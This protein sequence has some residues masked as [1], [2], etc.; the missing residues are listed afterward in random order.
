MVDASCHFL[1]DIPTYWFY[2]SVDIFILFHLVVTTYIR[3]ESMFATTSLATFHLCKLFVC[4]TVSTT[5]E[6]FAFIFQMPS[7]SEFHVNFLTCL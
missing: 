3:H 7:A 1:V 6:V 2:L 4:V 5:R